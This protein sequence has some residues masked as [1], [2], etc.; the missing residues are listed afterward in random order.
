MFNGGAQI[1]GSA[2]VEKIYAFEIKL[3]G[4]SVLSWPLCNRALLGAGKFRV[5]HSG[6][7]CGDLAL[8]DKDISQFTIVFFAPEM[9]IVFC[10][11]QLNMDAHV[12]C[13]SLNSA[14]QY[15]S[16][17]ELPRDLGQVVRRT[18]ETLCRCPRNNFEIGDLGESGENFFLNSIAKIFL[19]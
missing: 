10:L 5:Q 19:I 9:R 16:H 4:F 11:D 17:T 15:V 13:R 18:L 6:N 2:L 14:F 3:M 1:F 8:D 7:I 12:I